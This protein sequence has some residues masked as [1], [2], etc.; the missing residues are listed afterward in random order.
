MAYIIVKQPEWFTQEWLIDFL[1]FWKHKAPMIIDR[2]ITHRNLVLL[3]SKR[4]SYV[5]D[6]ISFCYKK[7]AG[8][9]IFINKLS[10][11]NVPNINLKGYMK[12]SEEKLAIFLRDFDYDRINEN[13]PEFFK[14]IT[15]MFQ[16][17][18]VNNS[19]TQK[20]KIEKIVL[21]YKDRFK[22]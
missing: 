13:N 18:S 1:M 21:H 19:L 8:D 11:D 5:W 4:N 9:R 15:N 10:F 20:E 22:I 6:A 14:V 7:I 2:N 3:E 12:T 17:D 16:V